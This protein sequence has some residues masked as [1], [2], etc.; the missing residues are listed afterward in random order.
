L[1][2]GLIGFSKAALAQQKRK[3]KERLRQQGNPCL[4][5]LGKKFI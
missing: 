1:V 3:E 5:E 2:A 4:R